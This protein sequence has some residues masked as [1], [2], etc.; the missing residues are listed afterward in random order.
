MLLRPHQCSAVFGGL[1]FKYSL[2]VIF[3]VDALFSFVIRCLIRLIIFVVLHFYGA[4]SFLSVV[5]D[6]RGSCVTYFLVRYM[7][8]LLDGCLGNYFPCFVYLCLLSAFVSRSLA[9]FFI[10]LRRIL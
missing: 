7:I 3:F 5:F 1:V 10:H 6:L 2:E 9:R 8:Y 4:Y